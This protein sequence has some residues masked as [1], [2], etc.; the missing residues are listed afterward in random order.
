MKT[1]HT[2][3]RRT[4]ALALCS[5]AL[6]AVAEL[7][8]D[9]QIERLGP[10]RIAVVWTGAAVAG[11]QYRIAVSDR[12]DAPLPASV[13]PVNGASGRIE[14]EHAAD[15]RPYVRIK[16]DEGRESLIGER[17]L[18]LE[19]GINFRDLGGYQAGDGRQVRWGRLFR[20]GAMDTLTDGDY[21][22]LQR[23]GIKTI[24]DLRRPQERNAAPTQAN[25]IGQEVEYLSW[26]YELKFDGDILKRA[27]AGGGDPKEAAIRMMSGFYRTMPKEFAPRYRTAFD[28]LKAGDGLLFNCSAGK[29]RTGLLAALVLTTLGVPQDTVIADYAMSQRVP[30][31][32][33][34]RQRSSDP[35]GDK[36]ADPTA[37]AFAKLPPEAVDALMGTDPVYLHSAFDQIR[38]DYG[39]ID[40][41]IER[42][43]G[44]SPADRIALQGMYLEPAR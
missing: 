23:L 3:K 28:A 33:K 30:S 6:P 37:A 10:T 35:T 7:P 21:A 27:F 8:R 18:P 15:V 43:L 19:G 22:Y 4:L 40:A 16:D 14:I 17:V 41:Y 34:L 29:D 26:D 36:A 20:S 1:A 31:L 12:I 5:C 2:L 13:S 25:R 24:C 32:Q 11:E 44:V 42:E 39:S 38:A 9:L